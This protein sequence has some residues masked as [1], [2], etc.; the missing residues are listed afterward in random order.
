MA[1]MF[2]LAGKV[3]RKKSSNSF[4]TSL[5]VKPIKHK[6]KKRNNS[7]YNRKS[8]KNILD[9]NWKGAKKKYPKMNPYGDIDFDGLINSR[10]CKPFDPSRDGRFSDF[11]SSVAKRYVGAKQKIRERATPYTDVGGGI[12][13]R[14]VR[15]PPGRKAE[16]R[17]KERL[18]EKARKEF[19]LR[20][21]T[22][23]KQADKA[24]IARRRSIART[25][26]KLKSELETEIG[27]LPTAEQIKVKRQVVVRPKKTRLQSK[28]EE[29]QMKELERL[30]KKKKKKGLSIRERASVA[31]MQKVIRKEEKQYLIS[32]RVAKKEY[33]K[34]LK[35]EKAQLFQ[36]Q[37]S[38]RKIRSD[39][40]R[41]SAQLSRESLGAESKLMREGRKQAFALEKAEKAK[42]K[43]EA[44][45][46]RDELRL[47]KYKF[48]QR[49][50]S[51]KRKKGRR[52]TYSIGG[53]SYSAG[54]GTTQRVTSQATVQGRGAG[55]PKGSYKFTDPISGE[56]VPVQVYKSSLR[57]IRARNLKRS[58]QSNIARRTAMARRGISPTLARQILEQ[59]RARLVQQSMPQQAQEM[60]EEEEMITESSTALPANT[61]T[62]GN[63]GPDIQEKI[64]R[65]PPGYFVTPEGRVMGP[66]QQSNAMKTA[67]NLF[68]SANGL[69]HKA[70]S[71][72]QRQ[73]EPQQYENEREQS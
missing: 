44:K 36:A 42:S 68:Q 24:V 60:V 10:D 30:L 40:F 33:R 73:P 70:K 11:I 22:L 66:P 29:V 6:K 21:E 16:A 56:K 9:L 17:R 54:R 37:A 43:S 14:L 38:E 32:K 47:E 59:K 15:V 3:N 7:K 61:D 31:G 72:V 5:I 18:K 63:M 8:N 50:I 25:K 52:S 58:E 57:Q 26:A 67:Q 13:R 41:T 27:K 20:K 35:L 62:S 46:R 34:Q 48:K 49:M 1:S 55:R 69:F 65:L 71:I 19:E 39:F 4:G 28:L 53:L 64:R 2:D 51:T 45:A 23:L 12:V